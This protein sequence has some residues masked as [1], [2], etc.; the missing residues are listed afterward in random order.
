MI[1]ATETELRETRIGEE[2]HSASIVR[3]WCEWL[4]WIFVDSSSF[5]CAI[6][7]ARRINQWRQTMPL[8]F[9]RPPERR[10]GRRYA[11]F[12]FPF[13]R[14]S[15]F[16]F[17]CQWWWLVT[18]PV[19]ACIVK[20]PNVTRRKK[21]EKGKK[22]KSRYPVYSTLHKFQIISHFVYPAPIHCLRSRWKH[23]RGLCSSHF[24]FKSEEFF[25]WQDRGRRR[26][27]RPMKMKK[28]GEVKRRCHLSWKAEQFESTHWSN[29][30]V[31]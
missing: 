17:N 15:F 13:S 1:L 21:G 27:K 11:I 3:G 18:Y 28:K 31:H 16:F 20:L 6:T 8:R 7:Y 29:C 23:S 14:F 10:I 30:P 19:S 25:C 9:K 5:V 22:E 24:D 4:S 12:I 26:G 2:D